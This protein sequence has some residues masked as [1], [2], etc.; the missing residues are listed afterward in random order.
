MSTRP[1][2]TMGPPLPLLYEVAPKP[3]ASHPHPIKLKGY[4]PSAAY[5]ELQRKAERR[6]EEQ[7]R[8]ANAERAETVV[9]EPEQSVRV[10]S[11]RSGSSWE[12]QR[13]K[14]VVSEPSSRLPYPRVRS[15]VHRDPQFTGLNGSRPRSVHLESPRPQVMVSGSTPLTPPPLRRQSSDPTPPRK[16][17]YGLYSSSRVSSAPRSVSVELD[18]DEDAH[19]TWAKAHK[20]WHEADELGP[21]QSVEKV[22]EGLE[23]FVLEHDP[24]VSRAYHRKSSEMRQVSFDLP[25]EETV[26]GKE[27]ARRAA[28]EA[29]EGANGSVGE[30]E[31]PV[32]KSANDCECS[33]ASGKARVPSNPRLVKTR[34]GSSEA[35]SG[36]PRMVSDGSGR[37][38]SVGKP[39]QASA[40][41]GSVPS[42]PF[43]SPS[44]LEE[45]RQHRVR[46]RS[47]SVVFRP[48]EPFEIKEEPGLKTEGL[49]IGRNWSID[50]E[51]YEAKAFGAVPA[52]P[53]APESVDPVSFNPLKPE[54]VRTEPK[55]EPRAEPQTKLKVE[56]KVEPIIEPR[57]NTKKESTKPEPL[58]SPVPTTNSKTTPDTGPDPTK[59]KRITI[60]LPYPS[61]LAAARNHLWLVFLSALIAVVATLWVLDERSEWCYYRC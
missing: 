20:M 31:K 49:K 29:L 52:E 24:L 55:T 26:E 28:Q 2:D 33:K 23:D 43:D 21:S 51:K 53:R 41:E 57:T 56:P 37:V 1:S 54:P 3:P 48:S 36:E 14:S 47:S 32:G 16:S 39:S 11:K 50:A 46:S 17:S 5:L 45:L 22:K 35:G 38:P 13:R 18:C 40:S 44:A 6:A 19:T 59:P 58:I 61:V 4:K 8:K 27:G 34:V 25:K 60:S 12:D 9:V 42:A 10:A 15:P 7:R 30:K